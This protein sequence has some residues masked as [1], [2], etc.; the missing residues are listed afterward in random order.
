MNATYRTTILHLPAT[1]LGLLAET[2]KVEHRCS[3]CQEQVGPDQ[4]ITHARGHEEEVVA[5]N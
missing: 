3:A 2:W 1:P 4:L 5:T